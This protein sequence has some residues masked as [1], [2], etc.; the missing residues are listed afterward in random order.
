VSGGYGV[1]SQFVPCG[2]ESPS[3]TTDHRRWCDEPPDTLAV[4]V[5]D[6]DAEQPVRRQ[7]SPARMTTTAVGTPRVPI[8]RAYIRVMRVV[9]G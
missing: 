6:V 5:V 8:S 1:Q 4:E 3:A 9:A 2:T 7:P